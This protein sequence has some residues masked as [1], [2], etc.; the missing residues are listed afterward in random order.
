MVTN[1]TAAGLLSLSD[2]R[3][4]TKGPEKP[5]NE[6]GGFEGE[7]VKPNKVLVGS[8][9]RKCNC[10]LCSLDYCD[11]SEEETGT[12]AASAEYWQKK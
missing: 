7:P 9:P 1:V 12:V 11:C 6:E 2:I 10:K 8:H 5:V 4:M 3:A